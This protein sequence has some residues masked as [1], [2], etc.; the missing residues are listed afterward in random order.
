[1][2]LYDYETDISVQ[3]EEAI[4]ESIEKGKQGGIA[5]D[6]ARGLQQGAYQTKLKTAKLMKQHQYPISETALMT[7]L[8]LEEIENL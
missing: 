3:R 4:A 8:Y 2:F 6:E 7:G 5:L 1:M